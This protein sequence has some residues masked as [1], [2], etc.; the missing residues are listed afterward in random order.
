[1]A[2]KFP[3][4]NFYNFKPS[5]KAGKQFD[6]GKKNSLMNGFENKDGN[7]NGETS[8]LESHSK[9][10][11]GN[12]P[13]LTN[14]VSKDKS[15]DDDT[16]DALTNGD[17]NISINSTNYE[18]HTGL[19]SA[20]NKNDFGEKTPLPSEDSYLGM[21]VEIEEPVFV[22][23]NN[24]RRTF[25]QTAF[26][27]HKVRCQLTQAQAPTDTVTENQNV[28]SNNK[29]KRRQP[30]NKSKKATDLAKIVQEKSLVNGNIEQHTLTR[31]TS[32]HI[33]EN[34]S[35]SSSSI[36]SINSDK[37]E[38]LNHNSTS[39]S[40][41][42]Q[43]SNNCSKLELQSQFKANCSTSFWEKNCV[44]DTVNEKQEGNSKSKERVDSL[45]TDTV[46]EKQDANSKSKEQVDSLRT[47]TVNEKH[48]ANSKSKEQVDSLRTVLE[49]SSENQINEQPA[50][51]G[52]N[53]PHISENCSMLLSSSILTRTDEVEIPPTPESD[54]RQSSVSSSSNCSEYELQYQPKAINSTLFWKENYVLDTVNEK[55]RKRVDSLR[56][57]HSLPDV[58][59]YTQ[60]LSRIDAE[61]VSSEE[62]YAVSEIDAA[63]SSDNI[64]EIDTHDDTLY[65]HVNEAEKVI[66][67]RQVIIENRKISSDTKLKLGK[68]QERLTFREK[69][70]ILPEL[71]RILNRKNL[72]TV[73]SSLK[74]AK[75]SSS[76]SSS[77]FNKLCN[78]LKL[79]KDKLEISEEERS[80]QSSGISK[81][82][83]E[84]NF[85]RNPFISLQ[86]TKQP[87]SIL[88]KPSHS[89]PNDSKESGN[90][91]SSEFSIIDYTAQ[92][93]V[94]TNNMTV[95][96]QSSY[97]A[98]DVSCLNK[99]GN[100]LLGCS[101]TGPGPPPP[102][103]LK[104]AKRNLERDNDESE[105]EIRTKKSKPR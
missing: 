1:M 95:P 36:R 67:S 55:P 47:D 33:L 98:Q 84:S 32:P 80:C 74:G 38:N 9:E 21:F 83:M 51:T 105:I 54:S 19:N 71:K 73:D 20:N 101:G 10:Y 15:D 65:G 92:Q 31:R 70:P 27:D 66:A 12:S 8:M 26:T 35:S 75:S 86:S 45:S 7:S 97:S 61:E 30:L 48:D 63:V 22:K 3:E 23:C 85:V 11:G 44:L 103:N 88:R 2:A 99:K 91:P 52:H 5:T 60:M 24:C 28:K 40:D 17:S 25:I 59:D 43:S 13:H 69:E 90:T 100:L 58:S 56:R 57:V 68:K 82:T 79:I 14:G 34:E 37:V 6:R 78:T 49:K 41:P 64:E 62:D 94:P 46:N 87:K 104:K 4:Q 53:S 39:E 76:S 93:N 29:P 77:D 50:F 89:F 81:G 72:K 16:N 18:N 96:R 42:R 102:N